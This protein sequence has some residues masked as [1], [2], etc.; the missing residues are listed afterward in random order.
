MNT[1]EE[2]SVADTLKVSRYESLSATDYHLG[3]LPVARSESKS[4]THRGALEVIGGMG[5][6]IWDAAMYPTRLFSSGASVRSHSS[7]SGKVTGSQT[8][9]SDTSTGHF[10]LEQGPHPALLTRGMKIFIQSPYDCVL[11]TRPALSDHLKWLDEHEKYEE[12]WN[13]LVN[14]PEAAGE[15]TEKSSGTSTPTTA[16]DLGVAQISQGQNSLVDFFAD[17][18]SQTGS[19]EANKNSK[20]SKEKRRVGAKWIQQLINRGQW[21]AA[22]KTCSLVLDN[23]SSWEHWV[24]IFAE[25]N[26]FKEITAHIPSEQLRPPISSTVYEVVLGHYISEDR[27]KLGE[28]LDTWQPELF[29]V[30]S[31]ISAIESRLKAGDITESSLEDSITGRDWRI[32]TDGLAKLY[33][34]DG[35]AQDAL[36]CYIRLQDADAAMTLIASHH[37]IDTVADDIPGLILLRV[38]KEQE[39]TAPLCE[40]E[41]ASAEP[42][43]LLVSEA[44]HGIVKPKTVIRQLDARKGMRPFLFLYMRALW[45]GETMD[46]TPTKRSR[47]DVVTNPL[48]AEGRTLV[49]D[50]AD[51]ALALYAEYD[52]ALLF[53]FLKSSQSYTLST[54]TSICEKRDYTP[55]LVYL[56]AKE[57]Q[58][59]RALRI[60]IEKLGDVSGAISFAKEQDDAELWNDLLNYSMNKPA[61][62]R[63]LLEEVGT[64]I[65]PITLVRRIPEGLEILGLRNALTRMIKEYELQDSISEGVMR[66]FR[67]EVAAGMGNLHSGQK[68]AIKFDIVV[69]EDLPRN[70]SHDP[71]QKLIRSQSQKIGYCCGCGE[72]IFE[73][74]TYFNR[75]TSMLV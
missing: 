38:S 32:L 64:A 55:E 65:D 1:H 21:A 13:L 9:M 48:A 23:A 33:L 71:V 24:W 60:I 12:A 11:A 74:G 57:G 30:G 8:S 62:I 61:F 39:K 42:I 44:H 10:H 49:N 17:D 70:T 7:A 58:T 25:A 26:K 50:S 31:I 35:R 15:P 27:V 53:E 73:G 51:T 69:E 68:K 45:K 14:S 40:L 43:R 5:G 6:S 54:A 37:L 52:R 29:D 67:G 34:A 28:L 18:S 63:A 66:V 59:K 75:T 2:V 16:Q 20:A 46:T 22:G 41:E 19:K 56:L 72:L 36:R 47:F 4:G 3:V